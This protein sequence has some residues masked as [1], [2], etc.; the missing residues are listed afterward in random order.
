MHYRV[1]KSLTI[2]ML[3]SA[4]CWVQAE[5]ADTGDLVVEEVIVIAKS[6]TFAN[7]QISQEMISQQSPVTS[8]LAV[9]DNLPGVSVQ[10]GDTYGFDDWSTTI[11]I[12]GFQV[13][14][15]DQQIGTTIDGIPNG[16]SNYG[17]GAK[18]NRYVDSENLAGA[19]VSQG[20][21][22][23]ASRSTEA[24][25][26]TIDFSTI[27]PARESGLTLSTTFGEDDAERYYARFDTGALFGSETYAWISVSHTE[28]T[29]WINQAAENERDHVAAKIEANF[30]RITLT[31]YAS[32]DDTH[33]DNYQRL[34]S[35]AD[36]AANQE[37]DQLTAEWTGIPYVDQLYRKGWST[38]R[39][40]TLAYLK[41]DF[42][43]TE[44]LR[45][46]GNVY[47]HKNQG[48]G[49]W[50][51][52]YLVDVVDDGAGNPQGEAT[53]AV[54]AQ[55]GS[56]LGTFQFVDAAGVALSPAPGCVS[57]IT[58]PYG[59][60]G[61]EF[62]PA[63]YPDGAIPVQSY[64]HT[65]Y[66]KERVGFNAD[67]VWDIEMDGFGNQLRGGIWYEDSTREEYRDWHK[68]TDTRV[69]YE[70]NRAEYWTQY[71]REYPQEILRWYIEDTV[72]VGPVSVS[73]GVRDF[74]VELDR[75]DN[76]RETPDISVDS[77]SDTL[78]SGGVVVQ[79]PVEGLEL[80]AGYA[81]NFSAFSDNLLERPLSDFGQ[82]E[83]E[84]AENIDFG[85]R[86]LADR[87]SVSAAYYDIEFDN[88]I[89]FLDNQST[90]GPNYI[91]GTNG[92]Y[93]NAGGIESDG[94]EVSLTWDVT[95]TLFLYAAYTDNTSEYIGTGDPAVDAELGITPGNTV[96]NMPETQFVLSLSWEDG[97]YRAGVSSKYTDER[98][99][100]FDNTW[101]ADDYTMV[102]AYLEVGG[103]AISDSLEK[104]RFSLVLNNAF[105]EVYLAG[106]SGQGVWLG[107]PRTVSFSVN[108][109]L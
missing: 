94:L 72:T 2:A 106:I 70:F 11:S 63:C 16:N 76:F 71:D 74:S 43:A 65:H 54:R 7:N 67:F 108:L 62:D 101:Q 8:P 46:N 90:A 21:A 48:R 27:A 64:R 52:P 15:A 5:Q 92:T 45:F 49:D 77:D 103:E 47:Y 75:E 81:E 105:D 80:F 96:V 14:L 41:L 89:I 97:P 37:W 86:Y 36:V 91:I 98:E 39:E 73:L 56:L 58:F 18:V 107:A 31:G 13:S 50:V 35:A 66:K 104:F 99:I 88:R 38:L 26:G 44:N 79:T 25:G 17:G 78:F 60:A 3:A 109:T 93:F 100:R 87:W 4:S 61:P 1:G 33:E 42:D 12:R 10:E 55:G 20:T 28:A 34:F 69:G 51:P 32:Y 22:D 24:L 95:D 102:D 19:A 29:D 23:I 53:G 82:L 6:E 84:T 9:I 68:I 30:D 85:V 59:G 40:N 83:P 57:S